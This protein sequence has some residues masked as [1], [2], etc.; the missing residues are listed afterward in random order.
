MY[1]NWRR[2]I[3]VT[4]SCGRCEMG[5]RNAF[6]RVFL[7]SHQSVDEIISFFWWRR[8]RRLSTASNYLARATSAPLWYSHVDLLVNQST[9]NNLF[10]FVMNSK[11]IV[12]SIPEDTH[13]CDT[14]ERSKDL[15]LVRRRKNSLKKLTTLGIPRRSPIQVLTEPDVA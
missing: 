14:H 10:P 3:C 7:S 9:M 15:P 1:I 2:L 4:R 13:S 6:L 12:V 11:M 5:T 8:Q